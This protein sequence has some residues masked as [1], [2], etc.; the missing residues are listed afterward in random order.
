M[1]A[2]FS[3]ILVVMTVMTIACAIQVPPTAAPTPTV[4]PT[5]PPTSSPTEAE[6]DTATVR[7]VAVYVHTSADVNSAVVDTVSGGDVVTVIECQGDW[8]EIEQGYIWRGCLEEYAEE[9]K[10]E[11]R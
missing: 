5:L 10:C 8:C 9:R 2:R 3:L 4:T 11:A 7:Q 6:A 1:T